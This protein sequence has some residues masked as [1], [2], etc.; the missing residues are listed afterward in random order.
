MVL[1]LLTSRFHHERE[2][3]TEIAKRARAHHIVVVQF[4]PF[5]I[6]P[7]TEHVNG[8]LYD[9]DKQDW[10][11]QQFMIPSRIYN[12]CS[13]KDE[14]NVKKALPII[15]WLHSRPE[16]IF[17]NNDLPNDINVYE[18]L[19]KNKQLA[20]YVP[21][22]KQASKITTLQLLQTKKDVIIKPLHSF[23]KQNMYHI[24]Y[25][26]RTFHVT[27]LER[28][29]FPTKSFQ[30]KDTFLSWLQSL[31]QTRDY[32]VQPILPQS[33]SPVHI[34]SILQKNS[35]GTWEE[36]AKVIPID[37][38]PYSFLFPLTEQTR[39]TA[40]K[41]LQHRLSKIDFTLLQ[42][43]LHVITKETPR[44]LENAFSHLFE[45]ELSLVLDAT[46]AVWL[47]QVDAKPT[48]TPFI[49]H[50]TDFA[51]KVYTAPLRYYQSLLS[52]KKKQEL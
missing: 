25:R 42:D 39:F 49:Q 13:Y 26:D 38:T 52:S 24:F 40:F 27:T 29:R 34:R 35:E 19:T 17:L 21:V 20:P 4:T 30:T 5:S 18:V 36:K 22:I 10:V 1:G 48:Y 46:G 51:E 7:K 3:Y 31:L 23:S 15:N 45:L 28:N 32:T 47:Y 41:N 33:T 44:T 14:K 2:F 11:E 12:R 6:D 50:N 8:L 37:N 16:T 9:T 43:S